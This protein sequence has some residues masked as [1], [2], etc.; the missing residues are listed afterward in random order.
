M[1]IN[2]NSV[3]NRA[4]SSQSVGFSALSVQKKI[5]KIFKITFKESMKKPLKECR[6]S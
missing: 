3:L 4:N 2:Q 5:R 6:K 1:S